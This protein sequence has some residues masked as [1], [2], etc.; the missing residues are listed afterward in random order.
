[1]ANKL[2]F[3][4][5]SCRRF[6]ISV[7]GSVNCPLGRRN[8]APGQHGASKQRSKPSAY[9]LQLT[10]TQK[11]KTYY[12][13]SDN[14]LR[15]YYTKASKTKQ[16]TN[17][18]LV[19]ALETRLDNMVYRMGFASTL[20]AARQMVVH[21]HLLVNGKNVNKPGYAIQVGDTI[22]LREKSK[23]IERYKEWFQFFERPLGYVERDK[24][25]LSAK[26]VRAP[27]RE[28]VPIQVD[29]HLVVEFMAR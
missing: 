17:I 11:L 16:Q 5:K 15:I 13:I 21:R 1:M 23:G 4:H 20:R 7:C 8:V 18:A 27:E 24:A 22:Q 26:L 10:E 29:D 28:E 9:G 3:S 6:G 14:Q 25:N 19:Q 2:T 12:G